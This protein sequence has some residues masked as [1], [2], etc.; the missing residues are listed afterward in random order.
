MIRGAAPW[1]ARLGAI[2]LLAV[3]VL[4]QTLGLVHRTAHSGLEHG[5]SQTFHQTHS[6]GMGHSP[7]HDHV[8]P[9]SPSLSSGH[10]NATATSWLERLF[11][12]H[13]EDGAACALYDAQTTVYGGFTPVVQVFIAQAATLLIAFSQIT[14]TARAAALF[15]A[16]GPPAAL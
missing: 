13:D 3:A 8:T 11:T 12:G 4:A 5:H 16:R 10:A 7:Q 15:E 2:A 1:W 9:D 14:S 6:A